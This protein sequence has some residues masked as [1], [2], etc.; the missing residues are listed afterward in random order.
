MVDGN[1][2]RV[3]FGSFGSFGISTSKGRYHIH[4]S[5]DTQKKMWRGQALCIPAI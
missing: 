3:F 5:F 1:L 4:L 2:P